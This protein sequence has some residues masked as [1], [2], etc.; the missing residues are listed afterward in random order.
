MSWLCDRVFIFVALQ[1]VCAVAM[2]GCWPPP[3]PYVERQSSSSSSLRFELWPLVDHLFSQSDFS[4]WINCCC[5]RRNAMGTD[6]RKWL[7]FCPSQIFLLIL[8]RSD[9]GPTATEGVIKVRN[10][11]GAVIGTSWARSLSRSFDRLFWERPRRT[12]KFSCHRNECCRC[13]F[14][15]YCSFSEHIPD[16]SGSCLEGDEERR[17]LISR[18]SSA[19]VWRE[20]RAPYLCAGLPPYRC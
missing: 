18:F 7:L 9:D 5:G 20:G 17:R 16:H 19:A 6:G 2:G 13:I 8:D 14:S 10:P 4:K 12:T 1:S 15:L 11:D 3:R